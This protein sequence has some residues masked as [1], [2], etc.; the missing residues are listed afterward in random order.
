[1]NTK[2]KSWKT[3]EEISD[4]FSCGEGIS[5]DHMAAIISK[6][7]H[8]PSVPV[9]DLEK[10]AERWESWICN[11]TKIHYQCAHEL[12]AIFAPEEKK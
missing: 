5:V 6:H 11:Q 12:R 7:F 1:M 8:E 2:D 10:L 4:Q 9:S 3:A